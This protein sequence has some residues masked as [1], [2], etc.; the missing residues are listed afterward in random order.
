MQ[1]FPTIIWWSSDTPERL[2][3][4]ECTDHVAKLGVTRPAEATMVLLVPASLR[5][6]DIGNLL[7]GGK[8]KVGKCHWQLGRGID[9]R[10]TS[11]TLTAAH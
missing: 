11:G 9:N 4:L 3:H 7:S 2:R 6:M 10:S 5:S 1:R 8:S